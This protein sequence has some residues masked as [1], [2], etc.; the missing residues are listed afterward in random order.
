MIGPDAVRADVW[1]WAARFFK[2]RRLAREAIDGGKVELNGVACKPARPV[3]AGET[4]RITKGNERFE[5]TVLA[6]SPTRGP[7]SV[8]Q[9]LYE[10][11]PDSRARREKQRALARLSHPVRPDHRPDKADRRKLHRFKRSES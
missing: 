1:L 8:A 5:I 4:M 9:A 2:T 3:K 10:E 7:A 11:T 6:V